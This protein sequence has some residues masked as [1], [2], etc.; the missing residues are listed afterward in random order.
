MKQAQVFKFSNSLALIGLIT[1]CFACTTSRF[2]KAEKS[3]SIVRIENNLF[4]ITKPGADTG[5]A[6]SVVE[7]MKN[8]G[9]EGMS[10]TV[11][12]QGKIVWSKGYGFRNKELNLTVDSA[13]AFQA[14]SI[15]KPIT[16]VASFR[17]VSKGL[18]NL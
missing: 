4:E 5:I 1:F 18:L 9:V 3:E 15:S 12:D 2:S 7:R 16:S 8:F 11:F 14:A 13:T 10:V 17:L 6:Y